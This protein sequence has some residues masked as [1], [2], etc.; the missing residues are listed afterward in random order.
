MD[1]RQL[2]T[3]VSVAELG[4]VAKA[5]EQLHVAQPALSRQIAALEA[6]LGVPLFD[7]VRGRLM[8]SG[9]GERLLVDCRSLLNYARDLREQAQ[10][11]RRPDAGVLKVAASP[12]FLENIFPQ[13]LRRYEA[14]FP[15]VRV[16]MMDHVGAASLALIERGE[17]H[18]A[19]GTP[20]MIGPGQQHIATDPLVVVEMLAAF[21]PSLP[22]GQSGSIEILELAPYPLLQTGTQYVIRRTFDAACRLAGFDP[23]TA[24][25]SLSPHALLAMAEAGHGIAIVPSAVRID[26][27]RLRVARVTYRR[28]PVSEPLG[29]HYDRR[30]PQPPYAVA[31]RRMLQEYLAEV[32]PI[33]RPVGGEKVK[34]KAYKANSL[35]RRP[36]PNP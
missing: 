24:L 30:R 9:P 1:L 22:M 23:N 21:T 33:A 6:E 17:I 15:E 4:T 35:S 26:H 25:E 31:F 32:W 10:A 29:L 8:L 19:Q 7:R 13:F 28:K 27:Y 14:R 20:S 11:M 16:Q 2:R 36:A 34:Y 18:L 12:H 3:F 5:A